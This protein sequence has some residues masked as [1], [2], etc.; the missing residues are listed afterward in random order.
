MKGRGK[1]LESSLPR[2]V[3][4]ISWDIS[5]PRDTAPCHH[6]TGIRITSHMKLCLPPNFILGFPARLLAIHKPYPNEFG[7]E[8]CHIKSIANKQ[9]SLWCL[10]LCWSHTRICVSRSGLFLPAAEK[11]YWPFYRWDCFPSLFFCS[12][13]YFC[14]GNFTVELA[15]V[16]GEGVSM[17]TWEKI[18]LNG[19]PLLI[20]RLE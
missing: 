1:G 18:N 5:P 15:K 16:L 8:F 12:G 14:T 9:A 4:V 20:D 2:R 11:S 19:N 13:P 10:P 3:R 7:C 17:K 6:W